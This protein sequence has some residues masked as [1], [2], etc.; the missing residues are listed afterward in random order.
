MFSCLEV[1]RNSAHSRAKGPDLYQPGATPQ[2]TSS[3]KVWINS[4]FKFQT[5]PLRVDTDGVQIVFGDMATDSRLQ[6]SFFGL[7]VCERQGKAIAGVVSKISQFHC[8]L[9]RLLSES[10]FPRCMDL[11]DNPAALILKILKSRKS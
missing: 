4:F 8:L 7:A 5:T 10:G 3:S 9:Q 2:E 11:Q 1:F 6:I